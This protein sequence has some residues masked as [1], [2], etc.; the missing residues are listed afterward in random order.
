MLRNCCACVCCLFALPFFFSN[1]M[2]DG[3]TDE[4][5][6]TDESTTQTLLR[7]VGDKNERTSERLSERANKRT[8]ERGR[9]AMCCVHTTC[10]LVIGPP[11]SLS[12]K[13]EKKKRVGIP[14][15][16]G[17]PPM[18][19]KA[20]RPFRAGPNEAPP[21]IPLEPLPLGSASSSLGW[22]GLDY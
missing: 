4:F 6:G 10:Q 3:R 16:L 18:L 1:L 13:N 12:T 2:T 15:G 8:E 19:G 7:C 11:I 14:W 9:R 17:L 21:C 20:A 22:I 5:W